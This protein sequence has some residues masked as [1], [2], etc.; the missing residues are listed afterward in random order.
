MKTTTGHL[1]SIELR[2][3]KTRVR[4]ALFALCVAGTAIVTLLTF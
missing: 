1:S 2:Q 4:D 3:R